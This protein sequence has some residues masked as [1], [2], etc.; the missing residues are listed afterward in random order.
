MNGM[1]QIES[2]EA[3]RVVESGS[4]RPPGELLR[5]AEARHAGGRGGLGLEYGRDEDDSARYLFS[6]EVED[7]DGAVWS[8]ILDA[9]TGDVLKDERIPVDDEG[10]PEESA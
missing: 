2:D 3:S 5:A 10:A 6:T 8:M 1:R 9:R 4:V 7:G